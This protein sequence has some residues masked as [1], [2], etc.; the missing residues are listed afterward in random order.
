MWAW[1]SLTSRLVWYWAALPWAALPCY[2]CWN[3]QAGMQSWFGQGRQASQAES[4]YSKSVVVAS[5]ATRAAGSMISWLNS[6]LLMAFIHKS[7]ARFSLDLL[8]GFEF[9]KI[10]SVLYDTDN[11]PKNVTAHQT[12]DWPNLVLDFWSWWGQT[13]AGFYDTNDRVY[14]WLAVGSTFKR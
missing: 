4:L 8:P 5:L 1:W 9:L 2:R 13:I 12:Q 14:R 3:S 7:S 6:L 10:K 11:T